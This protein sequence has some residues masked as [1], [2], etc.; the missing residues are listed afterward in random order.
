MAP[1][2]YRL[3][4]APD[5]PARV[6]AGRAVRV[7]GRARRGAVGREE[8]PQHWM[9]GSTNGYRAK[10]SPPVRAAPAHDRSPDELDAMRQLLQ[11]F[12]C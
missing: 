11:T 5:G 2:P 8:P 4:A 10:T 9:A 1:G 3:G 6:R 12:L 7:S